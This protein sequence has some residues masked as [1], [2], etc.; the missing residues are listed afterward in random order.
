[1]ADGLLSIDL[2]RDLPEALKPRTISIGVPQRQ[3]SA[4]EKMAA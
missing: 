2:K 1:M 4:P 3:I